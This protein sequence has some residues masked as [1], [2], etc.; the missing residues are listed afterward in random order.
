MKSTVHFFPGAGKVIGFC[1]TNKAI[2]AAL[3]G[4][5]VP[6]DLGLQKRRVFGKG[7]C[8]YLVRHLVS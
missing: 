3:V 5:L 2:A 4:A 7:L 8:Q 6:D 1:E